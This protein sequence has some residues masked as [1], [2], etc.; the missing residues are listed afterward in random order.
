[1]RPMERYGPMLLMGVVFI[2]P[3]IGVDVLYYLVWLP[4][5]MITQTLV[6]IGL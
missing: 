2:L 4:A 6:S 3:M 1:M 5:S